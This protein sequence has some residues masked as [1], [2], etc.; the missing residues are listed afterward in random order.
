[1]MRKLAI[2]FMVLALSVQGGVSGSISAVSSVPPEADA[3][4]GPQTGPRA[5]STWRN[6][7]TPSAAVAAVHRLLHQ[8]KI[9][10]DS[11]G[12]GL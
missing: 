9:L 8:E 3:S 12:A 6:P 11:E 4:D 1:M 5:I 10:F 2:G 7:V